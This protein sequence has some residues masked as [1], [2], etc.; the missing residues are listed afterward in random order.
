MKKLAL[1]FVSLLLFSCI[2][3][4]IATDSGKPTNDVVEADTI[5][6]TVALIEDDTL[7]DAVYGVHEYPMRVKALSV[8][9]HHNFDC[10][11]ER[12]MAVV[13]YKDTLILITDD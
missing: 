8:A 4:Q 10:H 12:I 2:Q 9:P 6:E 3:K 1:F 11:N 7:F 5:I 13:S